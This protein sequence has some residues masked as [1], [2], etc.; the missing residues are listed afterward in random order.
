MA[1]ADLDISWDAFKRRIR[2]DLEETEW[3]DLR[4]KRDALEADVEALQ[5][6]RRELEVELDRA[7]EAVQETGVELEIGAATETAMAKAEADVQATREELSDVKATIARKEE[8][9]D[10]LE[11]QMQS[12]REEAIEKENRRRE[13]AYEA[14][15]QRL[16][17]LSEQFRNAYGR[18]EQMERDLFGPN[19]PGDP[20]PGHN[21]ITRRSLG[22]EVSDLERLVTDLE[23][24]GY[25]VDL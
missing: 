15:V 10:R 17:S 13:E 21:P 18:V 2:E 1:D 14:A 23:E 6:K 3:A 8:A 20:M 4:D 25:K 22:F 9:I 7:K 12:Y 11:T 19:R 24:K 5:E 16:A